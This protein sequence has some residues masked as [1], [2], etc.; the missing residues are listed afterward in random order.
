MISA[1]LAF[2]VANAD[3][4]Q[5]FKHWVAAAMNRSEFPRSLQ[6]HAN[7]LFQPLRLLIKPRNKHEFGNATQRIA[8]QPFS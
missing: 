6:N 7:G 4:P 3:N 2:S 5:P 8:A 1:V